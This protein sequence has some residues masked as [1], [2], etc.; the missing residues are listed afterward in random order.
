MVEVTIFLSFEDGTVVV[1]MT[2]T[3]QRGSYFIF[4]IYSWGSEET[5]RKINPS[6]EK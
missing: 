6:V 2:F 1:L 3:L 5:T 4:L